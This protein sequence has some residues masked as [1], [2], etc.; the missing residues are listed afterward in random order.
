VIVPLPTRLTRRSG[1]FTLGPDTGVRAAPGGAAQAAGLLRTLLAPA[2]GL[3]LPADPDGRI[4][5]ELDEGLRRLGAEGYELTTGPEGVL[6]RAPGPAGL[7][8]GVQ[9]LRQLLPAAAL[10]PEPV[11]GVEW[12]LPAVR[13]TDVPRF[14]WR[15]SM[16][17]VARHFMPVEFLHRYVDL[18]AL[19]KLNVLHLHLTDDQGW[20]MPV[21]GFPELTETG[22]RRAES[23]VGR[24]GSGRFDG[25]PHGGHYTRAELAG[26]VD[27]A[28]SRGVTVMP[29]IEMPGHARAAL[30]AYP[31]LGNDPG[32]RLPVWTEWGVS[33]AVFG[34][35]DEAL[36][37]C[38]AVL[39]EVMEI[40]PGRHVHI[41]GDECPATEWAASP[42]ARARM[43][44]QGLTEPQ[45]LRG[46]FLGEI[47]EF[48]T[49]H[50]RIPVCWDEGED[51]ALPPEVVTMPWR[52]A[53]HG[54]AAVR[55]GHQ[56]VTAPWAH[57]YLDYPQADR[58]GE[59]LGQAGLVTLR[60]VH[61]YDPAPV[62]EYDGHAG[63]VLGTQAQLWTE[64]APTPAH[65]EYLAFP[66]LC[67]LAETAWARSG[68]AGERSWPGFVERLHH[69]AAR[70]DAL[71]VRYGPLSPR[72]TVPAAA[73]PS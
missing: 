1:T 20:R 28:A 59:P 48:L 16:L 23:M 7:R 2:T 36:D 30:A 38:R 21:A 51:A 24:A 65:V 13:I 10:A 67:A 43:A 31:Q 73:P 14:R 66:R 68:P 41:G 60:D 29:E 26:L 45:E 32:R 69:H 54:I 4:A 62:A 9:T 40:F 47:A 12:R 33:D 34:V 72:T 3:P 50:G 53:G 57:T 37:F 17:D 58:D 49:E 18:L 5:V 8:H 11:R 70:L 19:H 64:F 52:E 56:V 22:G 55:R 63:Q 44:A 25:T 61:G 46:W 42:S 39:T 71:G 27:H 15:G 35:H 6:L